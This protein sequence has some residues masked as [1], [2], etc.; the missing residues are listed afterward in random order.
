M[1]GGC[2]EPAC[3]PSCTAR[4]ALRRPRPPSPLPRLPLLASGLP[5]AASHTRMPPAAAAAAAAAASSS[6]PDRVYCPNPKVQFCGPAAA[7]KRDD[8]GVRQ[9]TASLSSSE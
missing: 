9:Q 8:T 6:P 4:P 1:A 3:S 2:P 7:S 5:A